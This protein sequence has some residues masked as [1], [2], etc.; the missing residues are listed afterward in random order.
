MSGRE[1]HHY[2]VDEAGDLTLFDRRKR[3]L[4]GQPGV[5]HTF[6]VGALLLLEPEARA[7]RLEQLRARLLADPLLRSAPSMLP[8]SRKTA[9]AFHAK[10]DL[11]EVRLE[12]FRALLQEHVKV[13]AA[14]R[15]KLR[16]ADD[17]Q[18]SFRRSGQK[19]DIESVYEQLL[20]PIFQPRLH[21]GDENRIVF[22]R[23]GQSDRTHAFRSAIRLAKNRFEQ[24]WH[25]GIDRPT[26]IR[27]ALPHDFAGLQAVDYFLWASNDSW[28]A[29]NRDS[30][31]P[32]E[33]DSGSSLIWT[34]RAGIGTASTT[35]PGIHLPPKS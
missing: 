35:R 2:F 24:R 34:T 6:V 4:I 10:N 18:A 28:N 32:C 31:R 23:R 26:E 21:K 30:S 14:F 1:I 27:S 20:I 9:L 13:F 3:V 29:G 15:R 22:A 12:V 17:F 5:S 19:R 7:S 33:T 16:I 11:P 8:S 25:K